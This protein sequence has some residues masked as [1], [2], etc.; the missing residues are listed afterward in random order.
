[1]MTDNIIPGSAGVGSPTAQ[2]S[3]SPQEIEFLS[4]VQKDIEETTSFRELVYTDIP[5][6][7]GASVLDQLNQNPQYTGR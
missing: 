2:M 3:I 7:L 1:M 6:S 4:R 5:P